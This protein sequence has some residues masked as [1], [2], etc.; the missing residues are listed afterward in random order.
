V[1]FGDTLAG[2][3]V[4]WF[5]W[6]LVCSSTRRDVL[7][8]GCQAVV[9]SQQRKGITMNLTNI[10][11]RYLFFTGNGAIGKTKVAGA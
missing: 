7:A 2:K 10:K 1:W 11:T 6:P 8:R 9:Q 5:W 3:P 4:C